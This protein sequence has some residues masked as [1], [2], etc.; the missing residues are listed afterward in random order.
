M[1]EEE[2]EKAKTTQQIASIIRSQAGHISSAVFKSTFGAQLD[3]FSLVVDD[4]LKYVLNLCDTVKVQAKTDK[5]D[6]IHTL[7][8]NRVKND[9]LDLLGEWKAGIGLDVGTALMGL[10]ESYRATPVLLDMLTNMVV[11]L[12]VRPHLERYFSEFYQPSYPNVTTAF[13]MLMEGQID[14]ATFNKVCL[15]HGWSTAWHDRLYE[16]YNKD[17]SSYMAFLMYK[18]GLIA[19]AKMKQCFRIDG[20]DE[21]WDRALYQVLHRRPTFRELTSLA[22]FVPLTDIWVSEVL[23][24]QGYLDTDIQ[25]ILQAIKMRPLRE[26][27][28]S[29]VGRYCWEFQIGRITRDAFEDALEDLG[30]L[31]KERELWLLWGDLRYADELIDEQVEIIKLRVQKGDITTK[32]EVIEELKTLGFVEE[33]ANLMAEDMY[34]RWMIP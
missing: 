30:L 19:E 16:I 33:K 18:R 34:W 17:P 21:S 13:R 7:I 4:R 29:V 15:R 32:E 26:E 6:P 22:D 9:S 3:S 8:W 11:N 10:D 1:A 23:R 20:Y 27:I 24:A 5:L 28:R 25:Y 31:P 14:R 2:E 12:A